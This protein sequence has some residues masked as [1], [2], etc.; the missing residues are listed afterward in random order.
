MEC[1]P[2][3][4]RTRI[5]SL[6]R[7]GAG[8]PLL[9]LHG[10]GSTKEDF[11]DLMHHPAFH[12]RRIVAYDAPGFG[13]TKCDDLRAVSIAF[14]QRAAEYVI[15]HHELDGFHLVGHSM[16]GLTALLLAADRRHRVLSFTNIEGNLSSEDCFLSR[17]IV[18]HPARDPE[19]FFAEFVERNRAAPAYSRAL[20][21]VSLE[22]KVRPEVV[23]SVF[24]SM[25]DL[26]DNAGLLDEFVGLPMQKMFVYGSMNRSL[27]Y[28][29]TLRRHGVRLA[30]I[31]QSGHFP[32]YANP[33]A[34]WSSLDD[35]VRSVES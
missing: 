32:M 5:A 30:E 24:H 1:R 11:A 13:E 25:V 6:V 10:F 4:V 14:L 23:P 33:P 31:P 9:L 17:Q 15:A 2:R 18:E 3:D 20:Y 35:F 29:S 34:L 12:G 7:E 26:S 19:R 16:G 27:T 28:L 8:T 22:C 21:A